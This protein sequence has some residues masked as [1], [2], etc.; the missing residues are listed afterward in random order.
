MEF[1][2]GFNSL[3]YYKLKYAPEYFYTIHTIY[4]AD[5]AFGLLAYVDDIILMEESRDKLKIL[6][7]T[8]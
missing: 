5:M 7:T 3:L 1:F 6:L 2:Q 4:T 8:K